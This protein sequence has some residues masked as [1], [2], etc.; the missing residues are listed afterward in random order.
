[1]VKKIKTT[2]SDIVNFEN[3]WAAKK[4]CLAG[5]NKYKI[6]ALEFELSPYNNINTLIDDLCSGSYKMLPYIE[7]DVFE[8]KERHILAPQFRDKVVQWAI[9][10]VLNPEFKKK[11]I[12]DSFACIEGRGTHS[13]INR[14]NYFIRCA[15]V[16]YGESAYVLQVDIKKFF[17]SIDRETLKNLYAKYLEDSQIVALIKTITDSSVTLGE[18][19]LPLGN[20]LSQLSANLYLNELDQYIKR[21]LSVKYYVRYMDDM[22]LI[23]KNKEEAKSI[24]A[25]VVNFLKEKLRLENNDKKTIY[26]PLGKGVKS[27]GYISFG[28]YRTLS[29]KDRR[30]IQKRIQ[31]ITNQNIAIKDQKELLMYATFKCRYSDSFR[32]CSKFLKE[33][34]SLFEYFQTYSG[35]Y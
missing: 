31:N 27:V 21:S 22:V 11:F 20:S 28:S 24:K 2:F 8:P 17:Y 15:K 26:Y 3:L 6:D 7:F 5:K 29:S 34:L 14:L 18:K 30:K 1:M 32:C 16:N 23:L 25:L 13:Y 9:C 10:R 4:K 33:N 35:N 12:K 19:G